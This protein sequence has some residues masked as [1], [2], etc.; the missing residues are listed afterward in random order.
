M[1][2]LMEGKDPATQERIRN[3][4]DRMRERAAERGQ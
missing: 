3:L 2:K 1:E 4:I